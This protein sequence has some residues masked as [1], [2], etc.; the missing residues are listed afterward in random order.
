MTLLEYAHPSHCG[1]AST[2][3]FCS[4][5]LACGLSCRGTPPLVL[6]TPV[7]RSTK[8]RV[9]SFTG[10]SG[11]ANLK[12]GAC[13]KK[14]RCVC[15][16]AGKLNAAAQ[17]KTDAF[18]ITDGGGDWR[19]ECTSQQAAVISG[20]PQPGA[21]FH[22]CP[23]FMLTLRLQAAGEDLGRAWEVCVAAL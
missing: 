5:G 12:S 10:A 22:Y 17:R 2:K 15:G 7:R 11:A 20:P 4:L 23:F 19:S 13:E 1:Y 18:P 21:A 8:Y 16:G 3:F 9:K 14:R 6:I